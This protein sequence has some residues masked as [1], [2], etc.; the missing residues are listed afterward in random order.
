M[1]DTPHTNGRIPHDYHMHSDISCDSEA[2]M[3][4]M[5]RSALARGITQITFTEHYDLHPLDYCYDHYDVALYFQNLNAAREVLAPEGLTIRAGV[6]L[7]EAHIFAAQLQPVLVQ[8][9]Y[10]IVLGSL[11]W[12]GD[13]SI[14]DRDYFRATTMQEMV[15][16]Y[17][18]E[19]LTMV[20]AGGFDILAHADVFK[21]VASEVYGTIPDAPFED[22]IRPIWQACIDGGIGIE[23]N[24]AAWRRGLDQPNPSET[25]LRWYK[26]MGGEILTV[27]SDSHHP[28]DV[29][30]ALDRALDLARRVGFTRVAIFERREIVDWAAI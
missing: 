9:P 10:D 18:T 12:V 23:I 26:A 3:I 22:L 27:G 30:F 29:G 17:Y 25:M 21:R 28:D 6:E 19:M 2:T 1:T 15:T 13:H 4:Q 16:A 5:G 8:H 7:G 14:F 11:H 20:Q 24:T